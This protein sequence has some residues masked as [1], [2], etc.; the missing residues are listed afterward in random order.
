MAIP[1]SPVRISPPPADWLP[2]IIERIVRRFAPVRIIL[3]GSHARGE[4]RPDSDLDLLV[5][6]P[7]AS[8]RRRAA[9]EIMSSLSDL[10]VSKDIIVSTPEHLAERGH[11]NGLVYKAALEEGQ[12][13]YEHA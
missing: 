4:A 11:V 1:P 8:D 6:L 10:P 13:I 7:K 5:V 12:V 3:F 2:V 9:V